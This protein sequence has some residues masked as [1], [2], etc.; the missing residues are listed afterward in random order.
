MGSAVGGGPILLVSHTGMFVRLYALTKDP[1]FLD[2]ARAG[3]LGR[4]AHVNP[5]NHVA[6]YYWASMNQGPGPWP[7]H[8]WWQIGWIMDYLVAEAELRTGGK[9]KFDRGFMTPKVGPNEPMG[10]KP[11]IINGE[12][13]NLVI[14]KELVKF[15]DPNVDYIAAQSLDNKKLFVIVLNSQD[16]ECKVN[17][18]VNLSHLDNMNKK[19]ETKSIQLSRFGAKILEISVTP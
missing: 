17:A 14:R 2:M 3:A 16:K 12:K 4:D 1:L 8:A 19:V 11:G 7:H 10:F 5:Q 18:T 6:S 15:N 9:V 13:V